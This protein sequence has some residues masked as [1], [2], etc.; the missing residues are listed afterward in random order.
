MNYS[1]ILYSLSL[2]PQN[3][4]PKTIESFVEQKLLAINL[5]KHKIND[6]EILRKK[7]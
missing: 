2:T 3:I 1:Y 4:F 6:C 5:R 7:M